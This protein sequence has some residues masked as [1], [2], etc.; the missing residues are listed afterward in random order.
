MVK[1]SIVVPCYKVEK[2]IAELI[3]SIQMQ[4]F[5]DIEIILVDD[6]SPD[7]TG[8]ICD[9]YASRDDRLRVIHKPNE[10]VGAARNDGMK[11]ATGE[12]IIFAD[13][14]DFLPENAI[15]L[16]YA[17]AV[18]TSADVV[19]GDISRIVADKEEKGQMF[20]E[21]FVTD[22]DTQIREIV[23]TIFY[24]TYCPN[25]YQGKASFGYGGPWNK[26]VRREHLM[27]NHIVFDTRV[28]GIYDDYIYC[29][30]TISTA[31]KVAYIRQIVY[32]Y[33]ILETSITNTYKNDT[34]AINQSIFQAW[35]EFLEKYDQ[36]REYTAAYYA[37]V[38]RRFNES[39]GRYFCSP[40]NP[41]SVMDRIHELRKTM[42]TAP[43]KDILQYVEKNKLERL[44]FIEYIL[45]KVNTAIGIWLFYYALL[46]YSKIKRRM[47]YRANKNGKD[48]NV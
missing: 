33:R 3:E 18:E 15:E 35:S 47:L 39:L 13:S 1:V 46:L 31:K 2:Y 28:K 26:L 23:K 19:M 21:E 32:Y 38:L 29:A 45:F 25:P 7:R 6:G 43:Y 37:S 8:A 4:T 11:A 16:L 40:D 41:R 10:G 48:K 30:Y 20:S 9:E 12:Y 17:K 22:N 5:K 24:R 36:H 42:H 44:H 27:N 14:D 34:L